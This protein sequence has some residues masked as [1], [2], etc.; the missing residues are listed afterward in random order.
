[1]NPTIHHFGQI[2]RDIESHLERS[3]W[4]TRTEI[5][6]DPIQRSRLVLVGYPGD[7]SSPFVEL[8]QPLGEDS[9]VWGALAKGGGWH[10]VCFNVASRA[11]GDEL[12]A[13]HRML[14]VT[15]WVPAVLFDGKPVRFLYSKSH[16]LIELL[17]HEDAG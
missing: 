17:A 16:E 14:P 3:F 1:M 10:H 5:V 4:E 8:V 9:P 7:T 11:A 2:V 15:D 12:L 6:T 13:R